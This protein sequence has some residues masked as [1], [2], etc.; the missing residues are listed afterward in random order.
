MKPGFEGLNVSTIIFV[1]ETCPLPQT[2]S[3]VTLRKPPLN[4]FENVTEIEVEVEAPLAPG[5]TV[6]E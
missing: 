6:H 5:G 3:G 2:F 1:L 4:E